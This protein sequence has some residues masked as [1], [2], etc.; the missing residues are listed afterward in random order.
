MITAH[1]FAV[2]QT[3]LFS[4]GSKSRFVPRDTYKIVRLLPP[5]QNDQQYRVKSNLD[6]HER[7]VKES[8][9]R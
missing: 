5:E 2:G 6:G 8:Q 9:I 4:P 1:K 7:V 3:V